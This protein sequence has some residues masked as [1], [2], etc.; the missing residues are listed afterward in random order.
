ME[1]FGGDEL[2]VE[3]RGQLFQLDVHGD[4]QPLQLHQQDSLLEGGQPGLLVGE[5]Y[6]EGDCLVE[7]EQLGRNQVFF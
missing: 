6:L 5:E 3:G 1:Q 4:G 2:D 7:D